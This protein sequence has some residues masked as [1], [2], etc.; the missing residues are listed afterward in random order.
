MQTSDL[1]QARKYFLKLNKL[2]QRINESSYYLGQIAESRGKTDKAMNWYEQV[3]GGH[4][5]VEAQLR[6]AVLQARAG[7]VEGARQRLQ[8]INV[9]SDQTQLQV[10]LAEGEILRGAKRF[11]EALD[12]YNHA[13][14]EMPNNIQLLYARALTAEKVERLDLALKDLRYIVNRE[15]ENAQALNAL[16]YTLVDRTDDV[17]EGLKYIKQAYK[18]KPDDAAILDSL[19]WAYYRLGNYQKSLDYLRQAFDKLKDAEI[20]AHLGEVLWITGDRKGARAVWNE[21]LSQTP[22]HQLLL[23]VIKRFTE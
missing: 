18:L 12:V 9:D 15:P 21:A 7:D 6:T 2:G 22:S 13:L 17:Q 5:L 11:Q 1:D 20:A 14:S 8:D 3:R 4:Y 19:G 10:Y 23:D 16:G